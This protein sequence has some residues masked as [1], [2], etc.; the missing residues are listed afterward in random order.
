[1]VQARARKDDAD[2]IGEGYTATKKVGHAPARSRAK[3]RLREAARQ[4]LAC[5]GVAGS[6]YVFIA[7][8]RTGQVEWARLLD[9]M[10][11]ALISLAPVLGAPAPSTPD[12]PNRANEK[13]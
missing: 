2:W 5:H 4:V 6:D 12:I 3:R 10:K 13:M 8:G 11:S 1:M 9:D 7:R